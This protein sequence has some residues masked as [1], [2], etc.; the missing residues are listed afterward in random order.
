MT[1]ELPRLEDQSGALASRFVVLTVRESFYGRED[2][3]LLDRF[4]PELPAILNW[5]LEGW[6]RLYQRGRFIA[7]RCLGGVDPAVRGLGESDWCV[8]AGPVRRGAG[9]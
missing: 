5:A 6:D 8:P 4:V 9:I 7:A 2:P 1:N 3:D